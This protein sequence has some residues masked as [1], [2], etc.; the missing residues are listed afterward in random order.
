M[1]GKYLGLNRGPDALARHDRADPLSSSSAAAHVAEPAAALLVCPTDARRPSIRPDASPT[2]PRAL[3]DG[4]PQQ[5][6]PMRG[7]VQD[8]S[9]A[10]DPID[11]AAMRE[12]E[13]RHHD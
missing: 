11:A 12:V 9:G 13:G 2:A 10:L 3:L 6:G 4:H 7:P 5:R 8:E 1:S